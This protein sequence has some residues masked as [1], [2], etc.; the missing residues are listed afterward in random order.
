MCPNANFS[1]FLLRA[2]PIVSGHTP[3]MVGIKP[4]WAADEMSSLSTALSLQHPHA[5]SSWRISIL[6]QY[7][8]PARIWLHANRDRT[9]GHKPPQLTL[10]K[11]SYKQLDTHNLLITYTESQAFGLQT[12]IRLN[13]H[14]QHFQAE[15]NL[16]I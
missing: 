12:V 10:S 6:L 1:C 3:G 7:A 4:R 2:H 11:A 9:R 15:P 13:T 14:H 8:A 16:L 5:H